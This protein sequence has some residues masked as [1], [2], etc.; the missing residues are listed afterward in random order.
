MCKLSGVAKLKYSP[1]EIAMFFEGGC[2]NAS[3][4]ICEVFHEA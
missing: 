3:D 4:S 1:D 2:A